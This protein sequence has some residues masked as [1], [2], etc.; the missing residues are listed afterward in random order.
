[1]QFCFASLHAQKQF[2]FESIEINSYVY[3]DDLAYSKNVW[4]KQLKSGFRPSAQNFDSL[5]YYSFKE[6][7]HLNITGGGGIQTRLQKS[8]PAFSDHS[9]NRL[10]WNTGLGFRTFRM[11]SVPYS[12]LTPYYDTLKNQF[13]EREQFQ[14]RQ[15]LIDIYNSLMLNHHSKLIPEMYGFVGF[16]FQTSFSISSKVRDA[17]S[18]SQQKWNT[19]QHRWEEI[20]S[21]N[22]TT[23]AP[24]RNN[25]LYAWTIPLGVGFDLSKEISIAG[26]IEYFHARRSPALTEKKYSEC[27]MFQLIIRYKL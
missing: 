12:Y 24:A 23:L 20:S 17:Y 19:S 4:P 8:I 11:A 25:M 22:D 1:M 15:S 14:L 26:G 27:A 7:F 16:G 21:T 9:R 18:S 5:N 6:W 13:S 3:T 2:F 10:E